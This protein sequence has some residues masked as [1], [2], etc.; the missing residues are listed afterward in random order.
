[1]LQQKGKTEN[2]KKTSGRETHM[3]ERPAWTLG[4]AAH[5]QQLSCRVGVLSS[6]A[7]LSKRS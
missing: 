5:L 4:M 2:R 3:S 6:V 7:E 1:M